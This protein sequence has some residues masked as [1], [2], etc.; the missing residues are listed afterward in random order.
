MQ[1][2]L[3]PSR[4]SF[5]LYPETVFLPLAPAA[6]WACPQHADEFLEITSSPMF[7]CHRTSAPWTLFGFGNEDSLMPVLTGADRY[8]CA[9][10]FTNEEIVESQSAAYIFGSTSKSCQTC[11]DLKTISRMRF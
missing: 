10:N 6:G 7:L 4:L 8:R 1:S 5:P 9:M 3:V 2:A 11:P